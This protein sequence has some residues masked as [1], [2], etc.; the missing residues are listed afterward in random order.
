MPEVECIA[1]DP[2]GAGSV[3]APVE[4][5]NAL[6]AVS[7]RGA[8]LGMITG[9]VTQLLSVATT[10]VLARLLRPQEFGLVAAANSVIV[11]FAALTTVGFGTA[12]V[13]EEA[14]DKRTAST[15]FWAAG[16]LGLITAG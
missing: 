8:R 15:L 7:A 4:A 6:R 16:G 9:G 10:I 14:P 12:L 11:I 5:G 2:V 3:P 1:V 13:R